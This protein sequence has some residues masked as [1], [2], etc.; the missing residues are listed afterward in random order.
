M[1]A[2]QYLE[3]VNK[4]NLMI[5]NKLQE[6]YQLRTIA[7]RVTVSL[8]ADRVKTSPTNIL[9]NTIAKIID[10]EWE[11][12]KLVDR[13]VDKRSLIVSQIDRIE[14]PKLYAIL[15][16]KYVQCMTVKEMQVKMNLQERQ[17]KNLQRDALMEFERIYGTNFE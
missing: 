4:L 13:L 16:Y 14:N 2:R 9:E 7:T 6:I 15:T 1:D 17:I 8:D 10:K 3:Q 5:D 12:N 11:V